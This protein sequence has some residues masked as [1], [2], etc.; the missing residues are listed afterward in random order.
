MGAPG[1]SA[2]HDNGDTGRAMSQENVEVVRALY[3]ATHRGDWETAMEFY[4]PDVVLD[5]VGMPESGRYCGRDAL[6]A[7]YRRWFGTWDQLEIDPERFIDADDRVVVVIRLAGV[8]KRSGLPT[9]IRAADVI[10][11]R[12]GKIVHQA[13]YTDPAQAFEA[14]GLRE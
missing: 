11:V 14:A 8:G 1:L 6:F 13:G 5:M 12:S 3:A 10:T 2:T 7:F 4:D 9:S